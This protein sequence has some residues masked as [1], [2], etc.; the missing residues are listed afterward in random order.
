MAEDIYML[1]QNKYMRLQRQAEQ[2]CAEAIEAVYK[3]HPELKQITDETSSINS[4]LIK[5]SLKHLPEAELESLKEQ[6]LSLKQKRDDYM[7]KN[8]IDKSIF[9]PQYVCNDCRDT[10][11]LDNGMR[12]HCFN[13]YY[14]QYK[15]GDADMKILERENFSTFDLSI[16]PEKTASGV[17]QRA[18]ME[19]L[20]AALEDYCEKFP[21]VPKK[22]IIISGLTGT[23]KSF[24]T[25]CI[26][27]ALDERMFSVIRLSSYKMIND[28]FDL[29]ISDSTEFNAELDRLCRVDVLI[30]DDLGTEL[31]KENFT[32]NTIYYLLDKRL[33]LD[34]AGIVS[35]NLS[36]KK[37]EDK[38]SDRIMS[39]LFNSNTA[40]TILLAGTD[41][42]LKRNN[43]TQSEN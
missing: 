15:F 12:C 31:M 26:A 34:K 16:F 5:A 19:H 38:Y 8:N 37:L 25:N 3:Q 6:L 9:T 35:T 18:Q 30:I 13:D 32:L 17:N 11:K 2:K 1:V 23:G 28:L 39:R 24:L 10:G 7:Q 41:V 43:K 40:N 42:R 27:K 21:Q 14:S 20:K 29:Y 4:A 33:E 22:N 36:P